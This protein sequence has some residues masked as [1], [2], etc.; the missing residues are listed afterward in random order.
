[1]TDAQFTQL[2]NLLQKA[3]EGAESAFF[4]WL[5]F[6]KALP[7]IGWLLTVVGI[8]FVLVRVVRA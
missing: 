5:F 1:M 2:M 7:V 3:G 6:E 8:V 4:W